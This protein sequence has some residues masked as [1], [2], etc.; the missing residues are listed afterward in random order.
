MMAPV[1]I[2]SESPSR[3]SSVLSVNCGGQKSDSARD[4]SSHRPTSFEDLRIFFCFFLLI[5][6]FAFLAWL[7]MIQTD[8]LLS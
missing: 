6:F 8:D 5:F 4:S 2:S 7:L 3:L 1:A